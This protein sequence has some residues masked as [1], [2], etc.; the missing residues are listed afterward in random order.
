MRELLRFSTADL[1]DAV[2]EA[3]QTHGLPNLTLT[4]CHGR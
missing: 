4:S 1:E 2:M 3:Q